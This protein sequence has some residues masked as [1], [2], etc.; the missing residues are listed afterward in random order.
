ME[1]GIYHEVQKDDALCAAHCLNSLLQGQYFSAGELTEIAETLDELER[2]TMAQN[3][4][5]SV[6]FLKFMAQDSKNVDLSGNFSVQV[7]IKA[8]EAF[9][10]SL[11]P[12][13]HPSEKNSREN[14]H[15]QNAFIANYMSHWFTIRKFGG[16]IWFNLNSLFKE[17]EYVSS[18]FLSLL[19]SQ[20]QQ[21][22]Y[23][24]FV[25][26]GILPESKADQF[27]EGLT[28]LPNYKKYQKP[29]QNQK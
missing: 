22:G 2:Q 14:P 18:T 1:F 11:I 26:K 19:L 5:D 24:I 27:L 4:I 3:G 8:L 16:S 6:D 9:N 7:L 17:P 15:L 12:L 21:E 20:L 23:T 29:K 13:F 25:V 28:E 10:I